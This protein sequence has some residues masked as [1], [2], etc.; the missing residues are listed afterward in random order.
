LTIPL[1]ALSHGAG[2]GRDASTRPLRKSRK[3]RGTLHLFL[4][5][6]SGTPALRSGP[7]ANIPL[8]DF[9]QFP[10]RGFTM[11]PIDPPYNSPSYF[12]SYQG[13]PQG[14]PGGDD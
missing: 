4:L 8:Q 10:Y 11:I 7:P 3:E 5:P 14:P 12:T 2:Q 1:L 6:K 13:D 9:F